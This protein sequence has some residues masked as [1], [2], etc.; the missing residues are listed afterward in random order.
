MKKHAASSL[1]VLLLLF[2]V[3]PA[4][5]AY[6]AP[7]PEEF[8]GQIISKEVT[9]EK[10]VVHRIEGNLKIVETYYHTPQQFSDRHPAQYAKWLERS[11]K[12]VEDTLSHNDR[13]ARSLPIDQRHFVGTH[14]LMIRLIIQRK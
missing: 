2:M 11:R 10:T 7:V 1:V 14:R 9:N 5:G 6:T 4:K 8:T 13:S 3:L 12:K